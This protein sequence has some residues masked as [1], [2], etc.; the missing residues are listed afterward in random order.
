MTAIKTPTTQEI[1]DQLDT[2]NLRKTTKKQLLENEHFLVEELRSLSAK[3]YEALKAL[4]ELESN[5]T[6]SIDRLQSVRQRL[7]DS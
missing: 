4:G 3:H 6:F 2:L 7:N 1:L 5:I